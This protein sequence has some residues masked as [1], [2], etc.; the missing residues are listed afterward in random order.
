MKKEYNA[1]T[2]SDKLRRIMQEHF[3]TDATSAQYKIIP[4]FN[5]EK[6]ETSEDSAFRLIIL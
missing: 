5:P 2:F 3:D 1:V 4:D 6:T